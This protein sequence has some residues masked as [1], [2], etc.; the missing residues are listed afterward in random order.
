MIL[1]ELD[2]D[3]PSLD[4]D[5]RHDF[6]NEVRCIAAH[7][8]S[9]LPKKFSVDNFWKILIECVDEEK[10]SELYLNVKIVKIVFDYGSYLMLDKCNK[11]VAILEVL[12]QGVMKVCKEQNWDD[13]IFEECHERVVE[14]DYCYRWIFGKPKQNRE[15]KL[16]A[17]VDCYHD[18][19][20][21]VAK[22]IIS[23]L[24]GNLVYEC[25]LIEDVPNEFVFAHKLGDFKW[26]S[27]SELE[28]YNKAKQCTAKIDVNDR[29][30]MD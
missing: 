3:L 26:T 19:D 13:S 28:F 9:F 27:N 30:K 5:R 24:E 20:K 6:R 16:V 25:N 14:A 22:M 23:D 10:E 29:G 8:F 12:H 18:I 15:R 17:T 2:L 7:Y 11:K 21:F 1:K 4:K